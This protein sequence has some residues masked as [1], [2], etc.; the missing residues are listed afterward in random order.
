[1]E[2]SDGCGRTLRPCLSP[3]A[4]GILSFKAGTKQPLGLPVGSSWVGGIYLSRWSFCPLTWVAKV[5]ASPKMS[6]LVG[7]WLLCGKAGAW[8]SMSSNVNT[9]ASWYFLWGALTNNTFFLLVCF[10]FL[11]FCLETNCHH[12]WYRGSVSRKKVVCSSAQLGP[13]QQSKGI[14]AGC[15]SVLSLKPPKQW[16]RGILT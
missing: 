2:M 8:L 15:C 16:G 11:L 10:P 12:V 3:W 14:P 6:V 9:S 4:L 1:M 5:C 13:T 7:N